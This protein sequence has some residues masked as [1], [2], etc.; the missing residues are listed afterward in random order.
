MIVRVYTVKPRYIERF[1][2]R[3]LAMHTRGATCY[4]DFLRIDDEKAAELGMDG[5]ICA[6]FQAAAKVS[7]AKCYLYLLTFRLG[8]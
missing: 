3:L 8:I 6:T 4:E 2:L 5:N 7:F 1:A